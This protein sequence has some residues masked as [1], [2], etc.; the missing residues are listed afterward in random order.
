MTGSQVFNYMS[1]LR[2]ATL[3]VK[4]IH[5]FVAPFNVIFH[6]PNYFCACFAETSYHLSENPP[7]CFYLALLSRHASYQYSDQI[8]G[9]LEELLLR[10]DKEC[11]LNIPN[12][13]CTRL[14][15]RR[16]AKMN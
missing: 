6:L 2:A 13:Y 15:D 7:V 14:T 11:G 5:P 3:S 4:H 8:L 10:V 12:K 16:P 1:I 9:G